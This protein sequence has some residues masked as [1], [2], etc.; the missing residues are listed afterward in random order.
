MGEEGQKRRRVGE[1][2]P[3]CRRHHRWFWV[4]WHH[5]TALQ[6]PHPHPIARTAR[7]RSKSEG[8]RLAEP[9]DRLIQSCSCFVLGT[10]RGSK[11]EKGREKHD[12]HTLK[13]SKK[14]GHLNQMT[15]LL[16]N[17]GR[18]KEESF[19]IPKASQHPGV[20]WLLRTTENKM[21]KD[22]H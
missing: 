22:S 11:R 7:G 15:P 19:F 4:G 14:S 13:K 21:G 2:P 9:L 16:F 12:R 8:H 1:S 6:T 18:S 20:P 17:T 10:D 3:Q 5:A